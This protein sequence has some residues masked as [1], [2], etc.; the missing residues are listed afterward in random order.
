MCTR[1]W[2]LVPFFQMSSKNNELKTTHNILRD[3]RVPFSVN[4]SRNS[5]MLGESSLTLTAQFSLFGATFKKIWSICFGGWGGGGG[6][7]VGNEF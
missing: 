3:C 2:P 1:Q 5:R 7:G 4:P 6:E